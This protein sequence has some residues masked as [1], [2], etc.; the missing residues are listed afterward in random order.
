[1]GD[2]SEAEAAYNRLASTNAV[3]EFTILVSNYLSLGQ[4]ELARATLKLLHDSNPDV[5]IRYLT[6]LVTQGIP[7]SWC[8]IRGRTFLSAAFFEAFRSSRQ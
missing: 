3:R 7:S 4:F 8:V 2:I 1:M 5:A 6:R